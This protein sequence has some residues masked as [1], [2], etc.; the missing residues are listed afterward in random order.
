[1]ERIRQGARQALKLTLEEH[2]PGASKTP[3]APGPASAPANGVSTDEGSPGHHAVAPDEDS[4]GSRSEGA[5]RAENNGA[6]VDSV[7][8]DNALADSEA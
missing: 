5:E 6:G 8:E 3:D 1:M 4:C 7:G 2:S